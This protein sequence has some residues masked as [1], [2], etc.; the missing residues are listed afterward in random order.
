M[1]V[2]RYLLDTDISSYLVKQG[3]PKAQ[4]RLGDAALGSVGLSVI[5]YAELLHGATFTSSPRWNTRF[6]E[7]FLYALPV[8]EWTKDAAYEYVQILSDLKR[9][10]MMIGNMDMLI[11]AHA[12]AL[13]ATLVTNNVRDFVRIPGLTIEN[14]AV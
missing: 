14:W 2:I 13:K 12:K 1:G 7:K 8:L 5:T 6:L 9:K 4:Q 10:G 11:A 3:A